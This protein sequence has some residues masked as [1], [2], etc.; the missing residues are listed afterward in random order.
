MANSAQH[1]A[2][3]AVF[4]PSGQVTRRVS[5]PFGPG[6]MNIFVE[7]KSRYERTVRNLESSNNREERGKCFERHCEKR[8][9]VDWGTS[10][11]VLQHNGVVFMA[12]IPFSCPHEGRCGMSNLLDRHLRAAQPSNRVR[13]IPVQPKPIPME[14]AN[15][16]N[17]GVGRTNIRVLTTNDMASSLCRGDRYPSLWDTTAPVQAAAEV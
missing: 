17:Q 7:R 3:V 12:F 5:A 14:V 13:A 8:R 9:M 4:T 10:V 11:S 15:M 1:A 2:L 6:E 16:R